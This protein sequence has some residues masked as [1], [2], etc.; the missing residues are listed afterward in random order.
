MFKVTWRNLLARKLR[1]FMSAFAVVLGV[2]FVGGS[3]IFTD[4]MGGA[5]DDIIEGSVSDVEIAYAGA[6]SFT[7]MEDNRVIEGSVVDRLRKVP[8]V[9]DVY[10][11]LQLQSVFVIGSNG[12]VI[13][14]F[15]PPGLAFNNAGSTNVQGEPILTLKEG[16][17]PKGRGEVALDAKTVEKSGYHVGDTVRLV[18]PG[19]PPTLTAQLAGVVEFGNGGLVG[20]T[21][22]IFDTAAM[23]QLFFDGKDVYN[24]ISLSAAEGTT[25]R[26][27][28]DAA[29]AVL[30][31]GLVATPGDVQVEQNKEDI[32]NSFLKYIRIFMLV[33]AGIS[34]VVGAFLIVNTFSIL[35]AQRSRELALLRA[36]GASRR[37]VIVSVLLEALAVGFIGSTFGL[38]LGIGLAQAIRALMGVVGIDLSN[39]SFPVTGT[40]VFW[41]YLLGMLVT[42]V[43]AVLPAVRASRAAPVSALR[44]DVA[45]PEATLRTRLLLG[46]VLALAGVG[47]VVLGFVV[48]GGG[49]GLS[50]IGLGLLAVLIGASLASPLVSRPVIAVFGTAYRRLFGSIGQLATQNS[51]RNPRRMAATSSALMIGIALVSLVAIFGRSAAASTDVSVDDNLTAQLIVS[52]AIGQPFSTAVATEVRG[53]PGVKA[54]AEVQVALP[55]VDGSANA[56]VAGIEPADLEQ[57]MRLDVVGGDLAD[58]G[59]G[60]IAITQSKADGGDLVVG[61]TVKAEFQAG[62]QELEVAAIFKSSATVP[63]DYLVTTGTLTKG[64]IAARD[65]QLF[66]VTDPG[67]DV[68]AVKQRID[69]LTKDLPTLT[70]KDPQGFADEQKSQINTFLNIIYSL[71]G[72]SIV[73]AILGVINTLGLSVI[74]RTKEIGLLRAV[75]VSRAQLRQMIRLEAVVIGVFGALLGVVLGVAFGVSLVTALHDQG[76]TELSVPWLQLVLF[77][78]AA[79][80]VGV[81]AAIVPGRR[82]AKLDVLKAISAE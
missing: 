56:F 44:D 69:T 58:L 61:D 30:P 53:V 71:L 59:P 77:I 15:G 25:Q 76:M 62:T 34:L 13:G 7:S 24:S 8:G 49:A 10:P 19:D 5:F 72:L 27:L 67:A 38:L 20:A 68:D 14:G 3:L 21:I 26:Q 81:L 54:V 79:G 37:Q 35:V 11:G 28:A 29:Q 17:Y 46:I 50:L 33:F 63:G 9:Q 43:A 40:T 80:L 52:N 73:I 41:C 55:T 64:G 78:V 16:H 2:A 74:E 82:A 18:T 60:K 6:G 39:A 65:S 22:T 4:A 12:K 42:V 47:S 45:L 75:G 31:D 23:Q 57:A 36:L 51:A 66:V 32:D 1:L 70:V 48:G